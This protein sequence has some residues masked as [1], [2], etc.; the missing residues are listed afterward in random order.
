MFNPF[1]F[2]SIQEGVQVKYEYNSIKNFGYIYIT[3]LTSSEMINVKVTVV[4]I[5]F[6]DE[7]QAQKE[8]KEYKRIN[9]K[10]T[11]SFMITEYFGFVSPFELEIEW[12]D[13][14]GKIFKICFTGIHG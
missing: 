13:K 6:R 11:V 5:K 9:N 2:I 8:I 12:Q 1:G 10:E 14:Y 4:S 7:A 3:N